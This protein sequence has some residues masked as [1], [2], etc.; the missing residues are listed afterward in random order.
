[1]ARPL[2]DRRLKAELVRLYRAADRHYHGL[3]HIEAL[4][5]LADEYRGSLSDPEAVQAAIWFHDAVYD[6][7]A[8]DNEARSAALARERLALR[9]DPDRL[10]RIAVM[11]EA[12][13]THVVPDFDDPDAAH[14]AALFLDMDLSIL[15]APP[16]E[17]ERYEAA[18]RREFGWVSDAAWG[19]G[20]A[21]VL[22]GFLDRPHIFHSDQFRQ[23]FEATARR[24]ISRSLD[25]LLNPD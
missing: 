5:R 1:M 10:A 15:G 20:R 11:I 24:N 14:D 17:F 19:S 21:A 2:I 22:Q 7:R 18:V 4:L 12:T 8:A 3:A 13:A 16:A 23:R 25:L 9:A 6:S